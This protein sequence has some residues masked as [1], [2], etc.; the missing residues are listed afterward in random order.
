MEVRFERSPEFPAFTIQDQGAGFN[1]TPFIY[2]GPKRLL[3][4]NGR[5]IAVAKMLSFDGLEYLGSGNAVKVT[6]ERTP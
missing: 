1:W 3:D 4:P 2:L 6:I 5:G